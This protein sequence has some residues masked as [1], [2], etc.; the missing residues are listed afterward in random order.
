MFDLQ[1]L[2]DDR[3]KDW[4]QDFVYK[5]KSHAAALGLT[6][7]EVD[8]VD[9]DSTSVSKLV[10]E[11]KELQRSDADPQIKQEFGKYKELVKNGPSDEL[12][13]KFPAVFT[14]TAMLAAPGV[15]E[16][17]RAFVVTLQQKPGFTHDIAE[18][19]GLG[20][21][22]AEALKADQPAFTERL[23]DLV[24]GVKEHQGE[25]DVSDSHLKSLE[26]DYQASHH[27]VK[28]TEA[29]EQQG[30]S[31]DLLEKLTSYKD[32]VVN[33]PSDR[34]KMAVPGILGMLAAPGILSRVTGLI[35]QLKGKPQFDELIG[36]DMGISEAAEPAVERAREAVG[37]GAPHTPETGSRG[38]SWKWFLPALAAFGLLLWGLSTMKAPQTAYHKRSIPAVTGAGPAAKTAEAF[39]I[40]DLR[41]APDP[42]GAVLSWTTNVPATGQVEYGLTPSYELGVSP[43]TVSMDDKSMVSSHNFALQGLRSGTRY[44]VR[45][46]SKDKA[47]HQV[48]SKPYSFVAP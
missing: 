11:E 27:L 37:A 3:L 45:A 31:G 4:L 42:K 20:D 36:K 13:A 46:I 44:Y 40:S 6:N 47:G 18:K 43:K 29:A 38:G 23:G 1:S 33:G 32:M 17:V 8:S 10:T 34:L 48:M 25:L 9:R 28:S 35:D 5:L 22:S 30:A 16:R 21:M 15:I 19:L 24:Q 39:A 14:S 12:K 2:G 41:F 7:S 26:S